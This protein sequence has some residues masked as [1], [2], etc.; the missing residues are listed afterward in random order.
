MAWPT[1]NDP[2]TEFVTIR[3]TK[4]EAADLDALAANHA[5]GVRSKAL[6]WALD[7]V[8]SAEK[9]KAA[10]NKQKPTGGGGL[11]QHD[12]DGAQ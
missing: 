2:R 8:V 4:S 1:T 6:R 12:E 5:G 11:H 10:K 9:R 7:R 3:L